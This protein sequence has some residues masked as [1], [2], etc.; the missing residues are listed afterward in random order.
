MSDIPLA[1]LARVPGLLIRL[2]FS[3]LKFKRMAKKSA[4]KVRRGMI[5]AGMSR[6]KAKTLADKYEETFSIRRLIAGATGGDGISSL[7]PF[8]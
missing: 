7:F 2:V 6:E 8:H 4:R 3:A 5:K 1:A